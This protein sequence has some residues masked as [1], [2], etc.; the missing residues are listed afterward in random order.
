MDPVIAGVHGG[1]HAVNSLPA[2]LKDFRSMWNRTAEAGSS[3]WRRQN[4]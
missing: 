4:E 1:A 3:R 2:T